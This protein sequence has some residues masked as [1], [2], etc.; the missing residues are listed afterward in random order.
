MVRVFR[1]VSLS[2]WVGFRNANNVWIS[3]R[4][5]LDE[6][7]REHCLRRNNAG[8]C[9]RWL[10]MFIHEMSR[11]ECDET[12]AQAKCGRLA[13]ARDNQPY[14]VPFNFAFDGG[15]YLYFFTTLGQK[16]EWMRSNPLVC[17]EVDDVENH[18]HWS[19]VIVFGRYEELPDTPDFQMARIHA[20]GCLQTRVMWWEP[21]YV[22]Q[23]HRDH[24]HS[25]T[26][27]F[28]R[29]KIENVTGHRATSDD[30]ETAPETHTVK[31]KWKQFLKAALAR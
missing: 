3:G 23:E 11:T 29:I 13:C 22:S 26:P 21:A 5:D 2:G 28:F 27:I 20:H 17:F 4:S 19:S 24:P 10:V 7:Q 6:Y 16:V 18:N 30:T 9:R 15:S 12:L 25:L 31:S 8:F 14:I 1:V